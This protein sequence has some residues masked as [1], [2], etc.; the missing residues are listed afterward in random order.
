M[1][2]R[3]SAEGSQGRRTR[4]RI[5][6]PPRDTSDD[7]DDP[8]AI[9][10]G[11]DCEIVDL[12]KEV[13]ELRV[14]V[15]DLKSRLEGIEVF[16]KEQFGVLEL[17]FLNFPAPQTQ[18]AVIEQISAATIN[19]LAMYHE[20]KTG[21]QKIIRELIRLWMFSENGSMYA[22][23]S[24]ATLARECIVLVN[25][26]SE[27][28]HRCARCAC[29]EWYWSNQENPPVICCRRC[30]RTIVSVFDASSQRNEFAV[31]DHI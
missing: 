23:I 12:R 31:R 13:A 22:P 9:V 19:I 1:R 3:D 11:G 30:S 15:Q 29:C 25:S 7:E 14:S 2:V 26:E 27:R 17:K 8:D 24:E 18:S 5:S 20:S 28:C 4:Q 10:G 16:T 6:S 21:L